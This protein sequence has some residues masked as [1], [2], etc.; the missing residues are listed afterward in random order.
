MHVSSTYLLVYPRNDVLNLEREER[1]GEGKGE[2]GSGEK[3][4]ECIGEFDKES[5]GTGQ[6]RKWYKYYKHPHL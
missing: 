6:G 5:E 2:K 1:E 4:R 3:R